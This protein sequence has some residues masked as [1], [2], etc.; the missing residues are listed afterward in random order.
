MGG[1]RGKQEAGDRAFPLSW[2]P[3]N[4][5]FKPSLGQ[6]MQDTRKIELVGR[7]SAA[8]SLIEVALGSVLHA[9]HVPFSGNFLSLNQGFLLCR[10]SV[11]AREE[12]LGSVSYGISNVSAVLK[13]LAPAGKKLG[14]MLSL[15]MQGFLFSAGEVLLGANLAGWM[16]GMALLSL[17]TFLQP[18]VT[19]YLFFG[20]ELFRAV[21][22]LVKKTLP[23][24]GLGWREI[25]WIFGALVL[26]KMCTALFLAWAAW[27]SRGRSELQDRLLALAGEQGAR[28]LEG[29]AP[30]RKAA[31]KLALR[32]LFR[33]L[34]LV[35]L[36]ATVF[37]LFLSEHSAAEKVWVLLRPLAVGFVFFYFSRTLTLD[38]WLARLYGTRLESFARSCQSALGQLRQKRA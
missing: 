37:F 7:Y 4:R 1:S 10:A 19:Y 18:L 32:D 9:F 34:F 17:W 36:A 28:P 15:S 12:G 27:R 6:A 29:E 24:T 5:T 25:A 14:P 3:E 8:L 33:P 16:L 13:S 30:T 21:D 31:V 35:S 20:A 38:R 22:Y 11:E 2:H 23:W 26:M